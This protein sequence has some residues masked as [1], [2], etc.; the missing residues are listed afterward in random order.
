MAPAYAMR[1]S[2]NSQTLRV[3]RTLGET[4]FTTS[5]SE[6]F[7]LQVD[8][9]LTY[10]GVK[11]DKNG[12]IVRWKHP[13]GY[14]LPLFQPQTC[15]NSISAIAKLDEAETIQYHKG[16]LYWYSSL[17]M[18]KLE[19]GIALPC[20]MLNKIFSPKMKKW[21]NQVGTSCSSK[22]PGHLELNEGQGK[23]PWDIILYKKTLIDDRGLVGTKNIICSYP[24]RPTNRRS[25]KTCCVTKVSKAKPEQWEGLDKRHI[26]FIVLL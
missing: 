7:K 1:F 14:T 19:L 12:E 17:G 16:A 18:S 9:K 10:L 25:P 11:L 23:A 2:K 26:T 13:P 8:A 4:G 24:T 3:W 15:G 5:P 21:C 20:Q 22:H 6:I